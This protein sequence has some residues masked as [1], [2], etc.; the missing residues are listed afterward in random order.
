MMSR[1]RVL[2]D[3]EDIW[4]L[5]CFFLWGPMKEL[6]YIHLQEVTGTVLLTRVSG[7]LFHGCTYLAYPRL[8][9]IKIQT[10]LCT[11]S[12]CKYT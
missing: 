11:M 2:G 12:I 8:Q 4:G 5:Q 7:V 1:E 10:L 6:M 9:R 3:S